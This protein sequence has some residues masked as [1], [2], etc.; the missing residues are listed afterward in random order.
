MRLSG[1]AVRPDWFALVMFTGIL[2]LAHL[3]AGVTGLSAND[4]I[5]RFTLLATLNVM[6]QLWGQPPDRP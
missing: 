6:V 1:G 5:L 3:A 4:I 2:T